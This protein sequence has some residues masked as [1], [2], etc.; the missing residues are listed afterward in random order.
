MKK[1]KNDDKKE[2]KQ[3]CEECGREVNS[4]LGGIC[5]DCFGY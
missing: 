2:I 5:S 1:E 3:V 4:T